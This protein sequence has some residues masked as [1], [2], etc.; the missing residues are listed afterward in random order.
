MLDAQDYPELKPFFKEISKALSFPQYTNNIEVFQEQIND[1]SW[2]KDTKVRISISNMGV[3]LA[4][5]DMQVRKLM[6]DILTDAMES[7]ETAVP[8]LILMNKE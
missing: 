4:E 7:G 1:L 5:E 3:F 6:V 8:L 2:L